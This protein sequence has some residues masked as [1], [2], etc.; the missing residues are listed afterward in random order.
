M[1][2]FI[3]TISIIA[4]PVL[5]AVTL[6]EVAHGWAAYKF[7]DPSAKLAGRL[8]L[9]PLKHLDLVGTLVF[10]ITRMVGWAKPVP[11][12]PGISEIPAGT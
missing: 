2:E 9:N 11:V 3:I 5:L 8:T 1:N 4:I 6:H 12:N 10:L 7:G